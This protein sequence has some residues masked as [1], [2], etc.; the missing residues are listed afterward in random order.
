MGEPFDPMHAL[1]KLIAQESQGPPKQRQFKADYLLCPGDITN[2]ASELG[3]DRGWGQLKA[4]K[5]ALGARELL[6]T[7]GNHEVHSRAAPRDDIPGMS[8]QALDPLAM[9]QRH[10]DYPCTCFSGEDRWVY[11]GRGYKLIELDHV[12]L[13]VI[14]SSHF[15][16]TTR[17]NEFERGRVSEVALIELEVELRSRVAQDKSRA[18]VALMHH[19]PIPHEST[20][21]AD[22][23]I[24]MHNGARLMQ[25]LEATGV[26]WLVIHG[27]KHAGRLIAAHGGMNSPIVLA[28]GSFGAALEGVLA[29]TSRLQ[30]YILELEVSDQSIEPTISGTIRSWYWT[31]AQWEKARKYEHGLPDRCG[32]QRP[33]I[34]LQ[35]LVN[36]LADVLQCGSERYLEWEEALDR[37]PALGCLMPDQTAFL[38]KVMEAKGL[39]ATWDNDFCFP[40]DV[41]Q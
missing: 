8:T 3:F 40:D 28:A 38:R 39:K 1:Q 7:T 5:A 11:W 41:A 24:Q 29:T 22:E 17:A 30:F 9:M 14:N 18:F 35:P 12:L 25:L 16:A 32:F 33:A 13:I 19:H 37:I 2:Q 4:L 36:S 31:G 15:H 34:S 6:A 27:H 26:A 23:S 21:A 10:G 20:T